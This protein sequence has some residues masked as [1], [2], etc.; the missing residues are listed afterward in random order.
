MRSFIF[1]SGVFRHADF[2]QQKGVESTRPLFERSKP[3]ARAILTLV[4]FVETMFLCCMT[5][6]KG[7]GSACRPLLFA[8][9]RMRGRGLF[10]AQDGLKASL[11]FPSDINH[12]CKA[13]MKRI[14]G[15]LSN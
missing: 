13:E 11:S 6:R 3:R 8:L 1:Y 2:S 4:S 10:W 7:I 9:V 5:H 15:P 14:A 12:V